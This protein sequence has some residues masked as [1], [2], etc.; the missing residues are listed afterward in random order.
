MS[1]F[2]FRCPY[3][4]MYLFLCVLYLSVFICYFRSFTLSIVRD[5][6]SLYV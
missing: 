5:L 2:R 6:V 4:F 1:L 3:Y